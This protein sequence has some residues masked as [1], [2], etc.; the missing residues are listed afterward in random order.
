M[1]AK[2]IEFRKVTKTY[3]DGFWRKPVPILRDLSFEV[4]AGGVFGFLGANG[5]GKTTSI[6]LLLG[7]QRP[8][9]GEVML[10]GRPPQDHEPRARI[11]YLPERPYFQEGLTATEFLN[12]HRDLFGSYLKKSKLPSNA[13]LLST[14]GLTGVEGRLLRDFSKGMLQRIGIAQ[15]LVNDPELVIL[16]EPMSGLDPVGRREIRHLI[17]RLH[18]EGRTV[19][20]ST[21]ILSDVEE[22]C[23][24]IVFL[25]KGIASYIG[26]VTPLLQDSKHPSWEIKFSVPQEKLSSGP[27]AARAEFRGSSQV[28]TT[29]DP[30]EGRAIMEWIWTAGG[31]VESY[32]KVAHSLEEALFERFE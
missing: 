30:S 19:F 18:Q 1:D 6:K 12:Y 15:A 14:V 11:G 4:S 29:T 10:F 31:R 16:D 8:T 17:S 13:E 7:L 26:P 5:A 21:H 3:L 22:I 9:A 23:D 27:W 2:V 32:Q 24:E 20:F 25:R 28:V